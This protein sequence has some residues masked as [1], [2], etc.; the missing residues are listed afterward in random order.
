MYSTA[1]TPPSGHEHSWTGAEKPLLNENYKPR[2]DESKWIYYPRNWLN[3]SVATS[4]ANGYTFS[5]RYAVGKLVSTFTWKAL[6]TLTAA[7]NSFRLKD[8]KLYLHNFFVLRV[9]TAQ[10][11]GA[12]GFVLSKTALC[13]IK[14]WDAERFLLS[15]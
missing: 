3:S 11:K 6:E 5:R 7:L 2:F 4:N 10:E 1:Q 9:Q 12:A 8:W 15:L 13:F 14:W